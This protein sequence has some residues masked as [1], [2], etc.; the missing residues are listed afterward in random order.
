MRTVSNRA[1]Q[2]LAFTPE[3]TEELARMDKAYRKA[4]E[5]LPS[6]A[7]DWQFA[8]GVLQLGIVAQAEEALKDEKMT[9][10]DLARKMGVSRAHV[11][12]ILNETG[13]FQLETIAKLS[14]ALNRDIAFRFIRK[15]EQVLVRPARVTVH[16][17]KHFQFSATRKKSKKGQ[18]EEIEEVAEEGP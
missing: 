17:V 15:T 3:M 12:K 9:R 6:L 1:K 2:D 8:L 10:A 11:S 18:V 5:G 14:V 4:S 16:E 7:A 13:N